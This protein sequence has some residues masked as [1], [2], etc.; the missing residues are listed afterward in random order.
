M[1]ILITG[2]NRGLGKELVNILLE[3][4]KD[5]DLYLTARSHVDEMQQYF[6]AN[7]PHNKITCKKLDIS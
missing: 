2:T 7:Y 4:H 3:K 6:N 1:R 5:F